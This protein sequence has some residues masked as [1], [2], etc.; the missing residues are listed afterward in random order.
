MN[1]LNLIIRQKI[2]SII[3]ILISVLGGV[4]IYWYINNLKSKIPENMQYQEVFV[5]KNDIKKGEKISKDLLE[6]QKLPEHIFS[7]KFVLSEDQIL[8][9][10]AASDILKGEIIYIDEIKGVNL[11]YAHNLKF[12]SYIPKNLR[13]V[14]VPINYFG[15]K[16]LLKVGDKIDVV[17][18]YYDQSDSKLKST[19]ILC[20]K[21]II[22]VEGNSGDDNDSSIKGD[23]FLSASILEENSNSSSLSNFLIVTFYLEPQEVE[24]VF[25]ALERGVLNLSI[26]SCSKAVAGY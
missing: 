12:S 24:K 18:T 21:E 4:F 8:G 2:F 6:K 19:T 15:D 9:N 16:V 23:D 1:R 17:S 11:S 26:C 10:E 5:A 25:L 14:S 20:G 3:F 7:E 22:L 13:A